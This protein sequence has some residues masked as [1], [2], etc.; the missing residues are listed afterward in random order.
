MY[1]S[2]VWTI[3]EKAVGFGGDIEQPKGLFYESKPQE[4]CRSFN[5]ISAT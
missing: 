1:T 2:N 5:I 4:I 3:I